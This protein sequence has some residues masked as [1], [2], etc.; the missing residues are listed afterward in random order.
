MY[1]LDEDM[2]DHLKSVNPEA[3]RNIIKR[4]LEACGRGMWTPS[5]KILE[6]LQ[7]LYNEAEDAIEGVS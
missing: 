6:K 2:A 4:M 3:F 7:E 5:E 1:A